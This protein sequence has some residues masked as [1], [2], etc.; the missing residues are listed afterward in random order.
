MTIRKEE[1]VLL[2]GINQRMRGKSLV[3][4]SLLI[5]LESIFIITNTT[6]TRKTCMTSLIHD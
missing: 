5:M 6:A 2:S 4:E 3:Q 1:G